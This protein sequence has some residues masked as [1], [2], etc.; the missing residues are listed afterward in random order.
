[1]LILASASPTRRQL[2]ENAGIIFGVEPASID[3][4][5]IA[6]SVNWT[7]TSGVTIALRL[8]EAKALAVSN[9]HPDAYV[10]G[11]DQTL[12]H[13]QIQLHKPA[14]LDAARAQLLL[15]RGEIH[16]LNAAVAIARHNKILWSHADSA[17]LTMRAFTEDELD[18][19]LTEEGDAILGSVGSYR[20]EGP[21][22]RLFDAIEGDYFTILGLPLLA[23]FKA[24]RQ[25]HPTP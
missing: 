6:Q 16:E 8:A 11:A 25:H 7:D 19:V 18:M 4:R 23:L 5:E 20:F 13:K 22:I 1:M 3:E 17:R 24:L 21:S 10:I 12:I 14:D 9:Q 15:L 2:L